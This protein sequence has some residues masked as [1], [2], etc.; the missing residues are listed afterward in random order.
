[1]GFHI[2]HN[3]LLGVFFVLVLSTGTFA[4]NQSL[5]NATIN[6]TLVKAL[7]INLVNG[8]LDFGDVVQA[9][10]STKVTRTPD[11]GIYL[12]VSGHPGHDV[13]IDYNNITLSNK[14]WSDSY[15]GTEGN[16]L[17]QPDVEY[18]NSDP[19]YSS[20]NPVVG[21]NSYNL[22]NSIDQPSL[23]LWIGGE[24]DIPQNQPNGDYSGQFVVTVSY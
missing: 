3:T 14:Q 4:Q 17:F 21:G 18:S 9:G 5:A 19:D 16:L 12:E 20:A 8:D 6:A 10:I 22:S 13:V 24:I 7:N 23:H 2:K 11:K 1:M 15:E